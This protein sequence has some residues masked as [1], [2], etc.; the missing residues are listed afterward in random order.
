MIAC[1]KTHHFRVEL[2]YALL[3]R[4][5]KPEMPKPG[6]PKPSEEGFVYPG[7]FWLVKSHVDP[8]FAVG[9]IS[10]SIQE[11]L[12]PPLVSGVSSKHECWDSCIMSVI[13]DCQGWI[14]RYLSTYKGEAINFS[15]SCHPIFP[16]PISRWKAL[17]QKN[18]QRCWLLCSNPGKEK[19][20]KPHWKLQLGP[21]WVGKKNLRCCFALVLGK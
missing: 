9:A 19:G 3:V 4:E 21:F 14:S 2:A 16:S 18:A 1:F 20:T 5:K 13:T 6:S 7:E 10:S 11:T 17:T 8:Q 15:V 12:V